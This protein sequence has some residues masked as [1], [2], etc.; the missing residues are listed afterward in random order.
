MR[1]KQNVQHASMKKKQHVLFNIFPENF[2]EV[3][4]DV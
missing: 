4:Q 2:Q 1:Q 3:E